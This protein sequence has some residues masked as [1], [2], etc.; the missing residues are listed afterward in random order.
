M[1]A[2]VGCGEGKADRMMG[3]VRA[4]AL[5]TVPMGAP[6]ATTAPAA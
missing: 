5:V 4:V 2:R 1:G 3:H 6:A